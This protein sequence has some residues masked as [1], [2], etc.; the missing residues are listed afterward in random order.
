MKYLRRLGH[1]NSAITLNIY[2]HTDLEQEKRVLNTLNSSRN[3]FFI[4]HISNF[5]K[6]ISH[7]KT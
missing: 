6:A 4:T 7:I 3:N 5:K 1:H 2:T